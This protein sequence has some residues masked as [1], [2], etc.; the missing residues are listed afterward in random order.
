[1]NFVGATARRVLPGLLVAGAGSAAG[2]GISRLVP[3]FPWLTASLILG[4][5]VGCLPQVRP[6]LDGVLKPGLAMSSRRLLRLGIV[7][8][9]LQVSLATIA[10]LGW[11]A[12]VAIVALVGV[13]F[14]LT[15]WIGRLFRLEGD[16]AVLLAAGFSICGVSAVGAM[17]AARGTDPKDAGTPTALVTLYGTL[18]IVVL[19]ALAGL[20]GFT[21]IQFGHWVGA[22][23]HDVGQV[24]ATA[25]TLGA[26][27][28]AAAVVVKLTRVLM[29]AP[30]VAITS[31]ATRRRGNAVGK[32]PA[33]VPLFILGFIALVLV[34]TFLPV[35]DVVL[36]IAGTVQSILLS[37]ALFAI[38]ASLRLEQLARSGVRG[39]AAGLVAW[40][41][42]L[43]L[44][45][46]IVWLA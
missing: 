36:A 43:A 42:I 11:I 45:L 31:I 33:I 22:S 27:A 32:Q 46:C 19:P 13:S 35:P 39:L 3:G 23:V 40:V 28:L 1:V 4:V 20:F 26:S 7:V 25:Q 41:V 8:L 24:V 17:S 10:R 38:G 34:R 5:L 15:Y 30:M 12:I 29:L 16:Q 14:V 37:M 18:A 9:G 2:Y 6:S 21:D 44:G